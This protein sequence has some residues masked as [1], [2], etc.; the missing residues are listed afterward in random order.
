MWFIIHTFGYLLLEA[1]WDRLLR[2]EPNDPME[3]YP[4]RQ[5]GLG[6]TEGADRDT[7]E[8]YASLIP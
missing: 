1:C 4:P 2:K 5:T 7:M 8:G 3:R 6:L